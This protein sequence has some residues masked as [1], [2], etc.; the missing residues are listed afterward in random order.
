MDLIA[1]SLYYQDIDIEDIEILSLD[2]EINLLH[3]I[4]YKELS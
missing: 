2:N 3:H 4:L 1:L